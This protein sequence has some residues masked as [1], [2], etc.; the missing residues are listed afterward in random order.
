MLSVRHNR[1]F[2][3]SV[4]KQ[5]AEALLTGDYTYTIRECQFL[6]DIKGCKNFSDDII[7]HGKDQ[8]E[9]DAN[10]DAVLR[11]LQ[12]HG[13]RLN[14]AKCK[15]AQDHVTLYGH[16][17]GR[18]GLAADPKKIEALVN[19]TS[20]RNVSGVKSLLGMAQYVSRFIPNYASITSPI[21]ELT[22]SDTPWIWDQ[23]HEQAFQNLQQTLA[24]I[25]AMTT[26]GNNPK[27]L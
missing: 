16:V 23:R 22:R 7:V 26:P 5:Q 3:E 1:S 24:S 8:A 4:P 27:P 14:I 10:L 20:P 13:L 9:H 19:S 17:F 21:R 11:C 18:D 6:H 2:W 25:Q 12:E 15:F